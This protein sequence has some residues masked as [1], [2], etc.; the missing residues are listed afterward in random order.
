MKQ[1][2]LP[3]PR[4]VVQ[5]VVVRRTPEPLRPSSKLGG[6]NA[7]LVD[8]ELR[9]ERGHERGVLELD[10]VERQG[11]LLRFR[12]RQSVLVLARWMS[13]PRN[14]GVVCVDGRWSLSPAYDIAPYIAFHASL[15]MSITREGHAQAT[16]WALLRDC[17]TFGCR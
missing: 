1:F 5:R 10:V 15:A 9:H 7:L 2:A 12:S 4:R 16:R 14:H 17:D 13:H 3:G 6:D 11:E 8:S